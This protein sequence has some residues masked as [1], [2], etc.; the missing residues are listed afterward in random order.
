MKKILKFFKKN[1]KRII[2][3]SMSIINLFA[4]FYL[5]YG[6]KLL[7]GI[8]DTVRL[9]I[10]IILIVLCLAFLFGYFKS[11]K[12]RKK[13]FYVYIPI[14]IIYSVILIVF[15][16]YISKTFNILSSMTTNSTTYS[17][18][19]VSLKDN[20]ADEINDITD[21]KI[22]IIEDES[23]VEGYEIPN[24][25]IESKKID[26]EIVEY[27]SYISL[28]KALYAE[29][30]KYAFLPTNYAIMFQNS[31]EEE[32]ATLE[33]DTKIIYSKE[34]VVKN[35]KTSKSGKLT[36]PFTVLVM[37]VDSE[38]ENI[39][40]SAVNGDALML[41]TFNPNTLNTTILSI[42]R[43][44]YVP[45]MCYS[46][47]ARSK[48]THAAVGG[49]DCMKSTIENFTGIT[50]DYYVKINFKGVVKLVD[51]L[52]G[53]DVD[54]PFAFCEQN[55]SRQWGN[56]TVY[57]EEG[58]QTL[59][60]EQALAFSRHREEVW[61]RKFC[62]RKWVDNG[63]VNDFV[64]GQHQQLVL[65]ALLNKL[66]NVRDLDT[67]YNLLDTISNNME[68]NMTT[69]EILSLYN[70]GKDILAKSGSEDASELLGFQRLYLSGT[71]GSY[72]EPGY[73][74]NLYM[75]SIYDDSLEQVTETMKINLG[76]IEPELIKEFSFDINTPYEETVIGKEVS[77]TKTNSGSKLPDFTGD[78]EVQAR[79]TASK[80][81]ISLKF[82]YVTEGSGK[83]GTVIAQNYKKGTAISSIKSLTLTILKEEKITENKE[84]KIT[85]DKIEL[86]NFVGL[87]EE[88]ASAKA[89]EIGIYINW[90]EA[91]SEKSVDK[92]I[93]QELPKGT[94]VDKGCTIKLTLG[95]AKKE[96][97][98]TPD[99]SISDEKETIDESQSTETD[100]STDNTENDSS[101]TDSSDS[102][103]VTIED[104]TGTTE[105]D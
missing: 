5:L 45:I 90:Q 21:G 91:E 36:E 95:I 6:I 76:L 48:I 25:I 104:A 74:T 54:V 80:L 59:N 98:I 96:T 7:D 60:G 51:A 43:D 52:G 40:N 63:T 81:G 105:L 19:I 8:E 53:V 42:P 14:T 47:H 99:D 28:I 101:A 39:S 12:K 92:V 89:K 71:D 64:R 103:N 66:K 35:K 27:E 16:H 57:V 69:S 32:L 41:I 65:K 62:A 17:S 23:S 29:E 102:G 72:H 100:T 10:S 9:L 44:S 70:I 49:V 2:L 77:S 58:F 78:T 82:K 86:P 13:M 88:Q 26:N 68:T 33:E 20:E 37:G 84:E 94:S 15:G 87:T 61:S 1:K 31:S 30:I 75:F 50:I 3:V 56:N 83:V 93:T 79:K 73:T 97:V 38:Q 11:F 22:G 24:E 67:V 4:T 85:S 18:S 34:K 55:S 46:G